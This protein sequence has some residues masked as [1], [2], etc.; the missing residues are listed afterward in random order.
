MGLHR[1]LRQ[2]LL[3]LALGAFGFPDVWALSCRDLPADADIPDLTA[4]G[5]CVASAFP[6]NK[7]SGGYIPDV[8]DA[9]GIDRIAVLSNE[10]LKVLE[11]LP[12]TRSGAQIN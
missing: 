11:T 4:A 1:V 7:A 2:G 10:M 8:A 12:A 6:L 5:A 9:G 3:L